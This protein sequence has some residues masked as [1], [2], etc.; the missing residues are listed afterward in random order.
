MVNCLLISLILAEETIV[1]ITVFG[2][3]NSDEVSAPLILQDGFNHNLFLLLG[4]LQKLVQVLLLDPI[5]L[6]DV[7]NLRVDFLLYFLD[8]LVEEAYLFLGI[9]G[10]SLV[11]RRPLLRLDNTDEIESVFDEIGLNFEIQGGLEC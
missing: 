5:E 1:E 3:I 2:R 4:Q 7:F 8:L 11:V 10:G 9:L 6:V